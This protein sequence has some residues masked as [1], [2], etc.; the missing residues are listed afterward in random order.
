LKQLSGI[1]LRFYKYGSIVF[2]MG[3]SVYIL[4]D[5]Y[6]LIIRFGGTYWA[7]YLALW[8]VYFTMYFVVFSFFYWTMIAV[9]ILSWRL[10]F[11]QW[12]S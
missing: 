8:L 5:D 4:I 7:E 6:S 11:R 9:G 3:Y 2:T 12:T 10:V 1:A